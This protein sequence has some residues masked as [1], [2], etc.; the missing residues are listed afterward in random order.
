MYWPSQVKTPNIDLDTWSAVFEK[1][2]RQNQSEDDE[3]CR[4]EQFHLILVWRQINGRDAEVEACA[5]NGESV[6][7]PQSRERGQIRDHLSENTVLATQVGLCAVQA[8]GNLIRGRAVV[9][10]WL[11]V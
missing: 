8:A 3:N 10:L 6:L 2:D 1:L 4:T 9:T 5:I 11:K 7:P